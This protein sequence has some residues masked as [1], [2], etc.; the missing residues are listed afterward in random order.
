MSAMSNLGYVV[1]ASKK[2]SEWKDFSVQI[3]GLQVS[4]YEPGDLLTLRMDDLQQ[5]IVIEDGPDED[6]RAIGWIFN[7]ENSLAEYVAKLRLAGAAVQ[8]CSAEQA[9]QRAVEILYYCEDSNGFNQEFACGAH[10]ANTLKPF[11]SPL[12]CGPGFKTG[13]LGIGHV[14][15]RA[16]DYP[17]TLDFYQNILGLHLSD[18]VRGEARPGFN[19]EAAFFHTVGGRHHSLATT[20]ANLPKKLGHLMM[21]LHNLEDVGMCYDR[22]KRAGLTFARELGRHVNDKMTSFYV[23]TPS[24]FAIEYGWGGMVVDDE[25]WTVRHYSQFSDWGHTRPGEISRN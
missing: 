3:L 15:V 16:S 18:T 2:L 24:G 25:K 11:A 17:A 10:Y 19:I 8:K 4:R 6:V 14:M 23:E 13:E 7:S 21:E 9:A 1:F 5:R 22:C 20:G 12:L